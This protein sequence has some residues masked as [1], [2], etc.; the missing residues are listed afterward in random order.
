M[1]QTTR[2]KPSADDCTRLAAVA[3]MRDGRATMAEAANLAGTSRQL[4]AFWARRAGIDPMQTRAQCLATI[5][6]R[7]LRQNE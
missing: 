2:R 6:A 3:L 1:T 7:A 5:W 4:V